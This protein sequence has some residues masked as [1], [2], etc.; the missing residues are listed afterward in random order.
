MPAVVTRVDPANADARHRWPH[1]LPDGRHFIYTEVFG[2]P[3]AGAKPSTIRIGSLEPSEA[4]VTLLQ[5]E[6]SAAYASGHVLFAR[7]ETLMAQPFDPETRQFAGG[8]F[9][10]AERVSQE[11][12]RYMGAS[13]SENGTLV[14]GSD[15]SLA[16]SELTWR[17]R[18]GRALGS[19]GGPAPYLNLALSPEERRVA[20][21]VGTGDRENVD[22]WIVDIAR[23]VRSRLTVDPGVH[24]TARVVAGRHASRL[25]EQPIGEDVVACETGGRH[26]PR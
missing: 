3:G 11:A 14:Y 5:A 25:P 1:F 17:D 13:V 21:A 19:V 16:V 20:V 2:A 6:S 9:P 24:G 26:E 7:D 4:D 18:T 22:I 23:N 8:A 12:S 15:D 10:V